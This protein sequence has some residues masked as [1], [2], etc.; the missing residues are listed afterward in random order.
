MEGIVRVAAVCG[1]VRQ[2]PDGVDH[3]DHGTGPTVGH[4]QRQRVLVRRLDV[5][6]VELHAVDLADKLRQRVQPRLDP[7]EVVLAQP[8][9]RERLQHLQLDPLR[10]VGDQLL[11]RPTRRGDAFA[12]CLE[13]L[14]GDV[15]VEGADVSGSLGGGAHADL[16]WSMVRCVLAET[17]VPMPRGRRSR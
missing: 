3:L 13:L 1:R 17:L 8:V 7:P 9:T 6:E 10:P 11:A 14:V 5:D 2:R 12:Q 15:D 4:D 16:L